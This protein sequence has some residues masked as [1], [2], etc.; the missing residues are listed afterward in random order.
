MSEQT[1]EVGPGGG[2][3]PVDPGDPGDPIDAAR[4]ALARARAAARARGLRPGRPGI[5]RRKDAPG[6]GLG[7]KDGTRDPKL[8]GDQ[9]DAF[10]AER[11]WRADISVGAV[12]GRWAQI[13]GPEVAA[14]SHPVEFVEGVLTVRADSTAWATQLR[15]LASTLHGALTEQVGEGVVTEIKVVGPS[16][17]S[18][19]HGPLRAT[20]GRGPRDTYG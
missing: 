19:S 9:I 20:D 10:V 11:G 13:V 3:D 8:L 4:D 2:V 17:R 6:A 12:I 7:V 16:A 14:H 5:R 1:P 18:W 15:L